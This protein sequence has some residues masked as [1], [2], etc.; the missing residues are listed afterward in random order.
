MHPLTPKDYIPRKDLLKIDNITEIIGTGVNNIKIIENF[1]SEKEISTALTFLK[2]YPVNENATH[3]YSLQQIQGHSASLDEL[4]FGE[5]MGRKMV[6]LGQN[7]YGQP[8][9]KDRPFLYVTH[10][11]GTYIDPHTDIL[12]VDDPDYDTPSFDE[13][14][15][16]F[17]YLWSGHLSILGYLNDDFEGGE[18][19]FPE[20]NYGFKPKMG[21][22]VLFPGNL[23]YVHGVAPITSGVRYTISQWCIFK[24]FIA[25]PS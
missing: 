2:K 19:Y 15:K 3:S 13:Q 1:L 22:V 11:T 18:L 6:E 10:P 20:L 8:L 4:F 17:P 21:S 9:I 7:L 24:N 23:H 25:K 14:V 16:E 5:M 12:D